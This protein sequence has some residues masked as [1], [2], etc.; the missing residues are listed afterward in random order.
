MGYSPWDYSH[1]SWIMG[2]QIW[3]VVWNI[4]FIFA[5]Y[6]GFLII[7]NDELIYFS[8]GW[9]ETTKQTWMLFGFFA[10]GSTKTGWWFGTFFI[11]PYVG[12]LI[13]PID[14]TIFQRGGPT[15]NQSRWVHPPAPRAAPGAAARSISATATTT[16]APRRRRRPGS[17][18][19]RA[20]RCGGAVG[21]GRSQ[22]W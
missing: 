9:R 19:R 20:M 16:C 3:S 13:I 14:F 7:P 1:Y 17:W 5:K 2:Y 15:T 4:N 18:P 6:I 11:F 8:E 10:G 22:R 12:F 21:S